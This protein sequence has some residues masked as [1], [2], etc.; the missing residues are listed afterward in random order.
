MIIA[1]VNL[2][3]AVTSV[4]IVMDPDPDPHRDGENGSGYPKGQPK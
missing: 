2:F 4:C 3:L 1:E